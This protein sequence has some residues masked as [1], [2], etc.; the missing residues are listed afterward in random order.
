MLHPDIVWASLVIA[1]LISV[2][3]YLRAAVLVGL[4]NGVPPVV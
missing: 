2:E 1:K 3:V 4:G